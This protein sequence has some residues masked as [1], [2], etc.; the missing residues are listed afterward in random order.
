MMYMILMGMRA[1]GSSLQTLVGGRVCTVRPP[2]PPQP[3]RVALL[4]FSC[5]CLAMTGPT[6]S[7]S[8]PPWPSQYIM[9]QSYYRYASVMWCWLCDM[10]MVMCV[11][12]YMNTCLTFTQ[13]RGVDWT[14]RCWDTLGHHGHGDVQNTQAHGMHTYLCNMI[15]YCLYT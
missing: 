14:R 15:G 10:I 6:V 7:A 4:Q 13:V 2:H 3:C 1:G 9:C 12:E 5:F 8:S 11:L